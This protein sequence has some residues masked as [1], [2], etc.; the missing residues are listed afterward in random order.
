MTTKVEWKEIWIYLLKW[1]V[2]I[3]IVLA[4]ITKGF[5]LLWAWMYFVQAN[6][7]NLWDTK[8]IFQQLLQI[9]YR[10]ETSSYVRNALKEGWG[11]LEPI[12][13]E[14]WMNMECECSEIKEYLVRD[15]KDNLQKLRTTEH[16]MCLS[17]N[18]PFNKV[19]DPKN[20]MPKHC[21]GMFNCHSTSIYVNDY[22]LKY[23]KVLRNII[24]IAEKPCYYLKDLPNKEENRRLY[25]NIDQ[26]RG[27]LYCDK[28]EGF[29]GD[30]TYIVIHVL[31]KEG[32]QSGQIIVPRIDNI[33]K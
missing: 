20:T 26:L 4:L 32:F 18:G 11:D 12:S 13:Y 30:K 6:N 24:K 9:P 10:K 17:I 33:Y 28:N 14:E 3:I 7:K 23:P 29:Y 31:D 22:I 2:G 21:T 25:N 8:D 16:L 27:E 15:I 19:R 1:M 5:L